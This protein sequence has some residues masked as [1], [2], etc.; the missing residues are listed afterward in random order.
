M[1][2]SKESLQSLAKDFKGEGEE[3]E[4]DLMN[5]DRLEGVSHSIEIQ[6]DKLDAQMLEQVSGL[7]G[8]D[9]HFPR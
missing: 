7:A 1:S 9:K 3:L 5:L 6:P 2:S 4:S 8:K